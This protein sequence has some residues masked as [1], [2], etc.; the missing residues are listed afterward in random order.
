MKILPSLI[1]AIVS[2]LSFR[3]PFLG[4]YASVNATSKANLTDSNQGGNANLEEELWTRQII[5]GADYQYPTNPLADGFMG[6]GDAGKAII[7]ITDTTKVNGSTIHITTYAG[8]A[9]GG[10]QGG[11]S[12]AGKEEKF[13]AGSFDVKIGR[14]W[15]GAGFDAISRDET[16]IGGRLDELIVEGLTFKHARKRNDDMLRLLLAQA[17]TTAR[18]LMFP[19]G[20]SGTVAG[21]K[22][23][24]Y[25]DTP[26]ITTSREVMTGLGALPMALGPKDSGGSRRSK[27]VFFGTNGVLSHLPFETAYLQAQ[28]SAGVRGNENSIFQGNITEWS[29]MMIYNWDQL[30]HGNAGPIGSLLAP[31]YYL[32]ANL[33]TLTWGSGS[34]WANR[35]GVAF[36]NTD[37]D[38]NDA[39][40][41]SQ[42]GVLIGNA[43]S[44]IVNAPDYTQYFSGA[45]WTYHNGDTI[46]IETSASKYVMIIGQSGA[47]AGKFGIFRYV[48]NSG[49]NIN[50]LN[51]VSIGG[52]NETADGQFLAGD[53]VVECNVLGTP[54]GYSLV[55][56]REALVCG[57]G[58]INGKAVNAKMGNRTTY[59]GPHGLDF[60]VGAEAVWG[61]AVVKRQDNVCP[62]FVAVRSAVPV[63]GAPT[64]S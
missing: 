19:V 58:S 2:L 21:L 12:R 9:G 51:G 17:N 41:A 42:T 26:T 57:V 49:N 50:L 16:M 40:L 53:L 31:R 14:W 47:N 56:G 6:E 37:T 36:T 27:F 5:A 11:T 48:T 13:R 34:T 59:E 15:T 52:A 28:Q 3:A 32:R 29:G 7:K 64:I 35:T 46:A 45:P 61:A 30:D 23:A 1:A 39:V 22:T 54:V 4:A 33:P 62:G 43:D 38:A 20:S 25:I 24:N 63:I 44:T 60:G 8:L 18:N 55:L 10:T